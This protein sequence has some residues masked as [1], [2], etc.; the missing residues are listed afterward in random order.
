[1]EYI[2][3]NMD[4]F[5]SYPYFKTL[6]DIAYWKENVKEF[7]IA[8]EKGKKEALCVRDNNTHSN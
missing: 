5:K 8:I 4:S 1:M 6:F 7:K 3:E 2:H